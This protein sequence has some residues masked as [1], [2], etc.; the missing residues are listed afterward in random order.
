M[1][2]LVQIWIKHFFLSFVYVILVFKKNQ[3][4]KFMIFHYGWYIFIIKISKIRKICNLLCYSQ[5]QFL[6]CRWYHFK[7]LTQI[8]PHWLQCYSSKWF[9]EIGIIVQKCCQIWVILPLHGKWLFFAIFCNYH[10]QEIDLLRNWIGKQQIE[11]K[12]ISVLIFSNLWN[13]DRKRMK[14]V[15]TVTNF[16]FKMAP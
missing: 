7:L 2:I 3:S 14:I 10:R 15:V 5:K 13:V 1:L 4:R 8:K 9:P 6:Y 12:L 16:C 11:N